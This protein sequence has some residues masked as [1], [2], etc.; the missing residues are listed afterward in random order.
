MTESKTPHATQEPVPTVPI[1]QAQAEASRGSQEPHTSRADENPSADQGDRTE[2]S[3]VRREAA[4]YRRRLRDTEAERD[5]LRAR[6][7]DYD[8][9]EVERLAADRL[10]DPRDLWAMT[11]VDGLRG[12][13]GTI[14]LEKARDEIGRVVQARPHWAKPMP[15]LHQ[16]ARQT[17]QEGPRS[18]FGQVIKGAL[19]G[20]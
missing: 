17:A 7:D 3:A 19:R 13:D 4:N 12:D 18:P 14:D 6:V 2:L 15:D 5:E 10:I 8:R 20:G 16:G 1:A 9:R 11:T